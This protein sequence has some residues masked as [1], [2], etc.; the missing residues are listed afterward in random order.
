M[1]RTR[2]RLLVW[3]VGTLLGSPVKAIDLLQS[4]QAALERDAEFKAAEATA[5]AGRQ[6]VPLARAQLLPN[7]NFNYTH[8]ENELNTRTEAFGRKFSQDSSYPSNNYALILRQPLYRPAQF[9]GYRQA[10]AQREGV[11]AEL[12]RATQEL[13]LRVAGAYLSALLMEERLVQVKAQHSAIAT[14]LAAASLALREGQGT[15]TDVDDAQARLDLNE[16][17]ML[18]AEQ[19]IAQARHELEILTGSPVNRLSPLDHRR[20]Q[21]VMPEP[22]TLGAW[23][24][25]AEA[26]SPELS[27]LE[28]ELQAARIEIS[29]AYAGHKPTADL[30]LQRSI[31]DSDNVVNP[32]AR[33]I[34]NQIG[35]QVAVPL[36]AGGYVQ[37]QVKQAMARHREAEER[38]EAS[39]RKLAAAVRKE[40]Q[41]VEEGIRRVQA[42]ELAERSATQ[43]VVSNRKGLLAGTRTRVDILDAIEKRSQT[44]LNLAEQ[45]LVYAISHLRLRALSGEL[46]TAAISRVNGWL[47]PA[48]PVAAPATA[49]PAP[50][51]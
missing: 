50:T 32:G 47:R 51:G 29:R 14:Q 49:S 34:N 2:L 27:A 33:Y 21:L 13:G 23:I 26:N 7:V 20:L 18:A 28:A 10:L 35:V 11:E 19:E 9:A 5:E 24:G 36:F 37:A 48:D 25:Q 16:V 38:L 4:Y 1:R 3:L 44:R 40:F 12:A 45:R 42:L 8:F 46:G 39:R 43:A 15:R 31:A 41:A 17:D 22:E 30:V 6:A